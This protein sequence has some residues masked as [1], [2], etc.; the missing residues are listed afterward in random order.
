V[1][2][3]LRSRLGWTA[4]DCTVQVVRHARGGW[5]VLRYTSGEPYVVYGKVY[6]DTAGQRRQ[7]LLAALHRAVPADVRVPRPLGYVRRIRMSLCDV[8]PGRAP[9]LAD[10]RERVSGVVAA[11]RTAAALHAA[12]V[13]PSSCRTLAAEV[14]ALRRR[15]IAIRSMWPDVVA[16]LVAALADVDA[17]AKSAPALPPTFCHGDFTPSQVLVDPAS[18]GVVDFDAAA[19]AEP[20]LDLGRFLAYLRFTLA[21]SG[22]QVG[23]FLAPA[24]LSAY[25]EAA[26]HR[27]RDV[28]ALTS[29]V[30][31]YER[32]SL[33]SLA[34]RACLHLKTGRLRMAL[35]L[36]SQLT[37]E[38]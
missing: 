2:P 25:A 15:L 10:A 33:L 31:V 38:V 3:E 18:I 28:A 35:A 30:A 22:S 20:A 36:L 23:P 14:A 8:V 21:K 29:R 11:A 6:A 1:F 27:S 12:P 16:Q 4:P 37:Q 17:Q 9:R 5:C 24:F 19:S 34:T 13:A 32:L 26:G 7:D